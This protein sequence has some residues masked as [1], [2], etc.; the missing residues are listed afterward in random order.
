MC[1]ENLVDGRRVPCQSSEPAA[2][3]GTVLSNPQSVLGL[4]RLSLV[5]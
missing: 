3:E 1:D 4:T 5:D 2:E